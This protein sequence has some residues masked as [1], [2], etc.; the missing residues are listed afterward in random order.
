M[1]NDWERRVLQRIEAQLRESDPD[2]VRMFR[3]GPPWALGQDMP[4]TLLVFGLALVVL[5]ALAALA[6]V[7]L[8]GMV[9]TLVALWSAWIGP[10]W[11]TRFA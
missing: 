5:G 4:R 9:L 1:L 10:R 11:S 7:T 2:L 8:F 3:E 6:P